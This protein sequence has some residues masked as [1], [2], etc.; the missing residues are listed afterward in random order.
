MPVHPGSGH[1]VKEK[2]LEKR[3][4]PLGGGMLVR[5]GLRQ[6]VR[7]KFFRKKKN[8]AGGGEGCLIRRGGC[9]LPAVPARS[10]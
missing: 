2:I 4:T 8:P 6:E 9:R 7:E 1:D 10:A 3:K 5:R